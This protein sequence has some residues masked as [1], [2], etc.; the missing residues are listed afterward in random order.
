M[1]VL[2]LIDSV[3]DTADAESGTVAVFG[4][5]SWAVCSVMGSYVKVLSVGATP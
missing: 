2:A 3:A 5:S 1:E 4:E